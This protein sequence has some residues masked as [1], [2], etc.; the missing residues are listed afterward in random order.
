MS[1]RK[2]ISHARTATAVMSGSQALGGPAQAILSLTNRHTVY[3]DCRRHDP[4]GTIFQN[5]FRE[6]RYGKAYHSFRIATLRKSGSANSVR[7][8]DCAR[9]VF[10][11]ANL[12]VYTRLSIH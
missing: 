8:C 6:T 5:E 7:G 9:C 11:A 4:L 10:I 12:C 2:W 3:P 1:V